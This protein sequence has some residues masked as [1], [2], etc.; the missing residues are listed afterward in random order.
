MAGKKREVSLRRK[1]LKA[2][3]LW[4]DGNDPVREG[5]IDGE[6]ERGDG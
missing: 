3:C 1:T 6:E 4:V 2:A 5:K